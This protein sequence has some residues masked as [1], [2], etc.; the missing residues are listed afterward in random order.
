M[1]K[2]EVGQLL[3]IASGFDRFIIVDRVTTEAWFLALTN[4]DYLQAQEALVAHFTGPASKETFRVTHIL[5]AVAVTNRATKSLAATDV[6]AARARGIVPPVWSELKPLTVALKSQ[7]AE[8]READRVVAN[9]WA[10]E[11]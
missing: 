5:D 9:R 4:I 8:A 10:V 3:T 11:A 7:L 1:N 6:R 2:P